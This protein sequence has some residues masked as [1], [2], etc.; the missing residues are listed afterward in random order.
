[1]AD[2][3][4]RL[5]EEGH[6]FNF[7]QAL[8]LL[9]EKYRGEE[10]V[11]S[12]VESGRVRMASGT[13]LA[14]PA[15]DIAS[16]KETASGI[17]FVLSFMGLVGV[18]SPLPLY[19]TEYLLRHE[20]ASGPLRDFLA[21]FNHR[22]YTLFYRAWQKYRCISMAAGP[23]ASPVARRMAGLAGLGGADLSDPF[24]RRA[25]AYTGS[26]AGK[27]RSKEALR[28]ML[29]DFFGGL[30]V[31]LCEWQPR[32]VDIADLPKLGIDSRLG[33]TSMLGTKKWDVSGKFR[34]SIGP[35]PRVTFETFLRNSENIAA[36]KKLV[37]LFLND[38][39]EFD[40][41]VKLESSELVPVI[42]GQDNT[43]LGE[44]SS[45]GKSDKRSGVSSIVIE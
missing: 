38:P 2:L 23:A 18:S 24:Y 29:A 32:W 8:S 4:A 25:L 21:I 37:N 22:M 45:L 20:E 31:A 6:N 34:V 36:V 39:L 19:F 5:R 14:F 16:V 28:A 11:G 9:E 44:T 10:G 17:E 35:L 12:P 40:I 33:V 3:I 15:S 7:F 1:M 43:R 41:E 27:V 30:P 42:L 26:L 13:S